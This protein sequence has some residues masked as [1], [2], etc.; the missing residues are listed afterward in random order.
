[1]HLLWRVTGFDGFYAEH[2]QTQLANELQTDPALQ[3]QS[4]RTPGCLA[5][6]I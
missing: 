4:R 6:F 5:S 3:R 1:V 2:L